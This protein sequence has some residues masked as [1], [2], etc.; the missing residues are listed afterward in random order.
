MW[1]HADGWTVAG[2]TSWNAQTRNMEAVSS[3][4]TV[5]YHCNVT[6]PLHS[7]AV[8]KLKWCE[9]DSFWKD[10]YVY[11]CFGTKPDTNSNM[12][13]WCCCLYLWTF[14]GK[15]VHCSVMSECDPQS[16]IASSFC[17]WSS[18]HQ[19]WVV[20][21]QD[22]IV[23]VDLL[24]ICNIQGASWV[25]VMTVDD[26]LCSCDKKRLYTHVWFWMLVEL[27]PLNTWNRRWGLLERNGMQL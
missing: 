11:S 24:F 1:Q 13:G 10:I 20:K 18:L 3:S 23:N 21:W 6:V 8:V 22:R 27:W 17:S 4:E 14:L 7:Q 5:S 15:C 26:F 2:Y 25:V 9:A 19:L 12:Y 16:L